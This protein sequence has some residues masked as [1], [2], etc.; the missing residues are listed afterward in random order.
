[1]SRG[2]LYVIRE[3][4]GQMKEIILNFICVKCSAKFKAKQGSRRQ[5]CDKCLC[6]VVKAGKKKDKN[7]GPVSQS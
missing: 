4:E 7:V 1:V 6:E 2:V 3:M 5:Y